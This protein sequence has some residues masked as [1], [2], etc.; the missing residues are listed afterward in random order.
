MIDGAPGKERFN[1]AEQAMRKLQSAVGTAALAAT[2]AAC[3]SERV[4]RDATDAAASPP[5]SAD[6]L[7]DAVME[8]SGGREMWD[9]TRFIRFRWLVERDGEIVADRRHSW[10]RYGGNYRLEFE[11]DGQ[12]TLA[13]FDVNSIKHEDRPMAGDVW[14][15][16]LKLDGSARD[17]ALERSYAM[18]INDTYWLLMPLKWKDPG[19]HLAYEGSKRLSDGR[20]YPTVHLTYDEGLGVTEDEFWGFVD[21]ETG[22]MAAW[23]YHLEGREEKGEVVWWRDWQQVG[24]LR[25]AMDRRW[26][27]G[28]TRIYFMDVAAS[29]EVPP[30]EFL[31][32]AH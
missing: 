30:A 8:A 9:K 6:L 11:R 17:S 26:D 15:D 5:D 3:D 4:S 31:P 27:E 20:R 18:F 16:G 32:P 21:P 29:L 7:A 14:V 25:L 22:L 24:P 1:R 13:L 10:D 28:A 23:Q 12:H 2:L 19:V